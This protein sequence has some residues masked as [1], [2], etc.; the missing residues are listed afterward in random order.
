LGLNAGIKWNPA[1]GQDSGGGLGAKLSEDRDNA[2][3]A[4]GKNSLNTQ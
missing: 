2:G 1:L 3:N 4:T